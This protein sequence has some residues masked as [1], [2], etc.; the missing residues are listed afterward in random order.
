MYYYSAIL[1]CGDKQ[2]SDG[3]LN[4]G[5]LYMG[6]AYVALCVINACV[7]CGWMEWSCM[8]VERVTQ[9]KRSSW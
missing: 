8:G 9:E 3:I 1:L 2:S 4:L 7:F 6:G 5:I